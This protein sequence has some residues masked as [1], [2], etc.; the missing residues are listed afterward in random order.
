MYNVSKGSLT[1][2]EPALECEAAFLDVKREVVDV[3][4]AGCDDLDGLVVAHHSVIC[5]VNIRNVR[6]LP[7]I[8]ATGRKEQ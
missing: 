6:R 3:E 2:V 8:H 4:R 5:H 7:H 1:C